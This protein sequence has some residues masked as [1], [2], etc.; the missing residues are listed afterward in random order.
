MQGQHP[1][2]NPPSQHL[3]RRGLLGVPTGGSQK[4]RYWRGAPSAD[5]YPLSCS[6][7]YPPIVP[8]VP[9]RGTRATHPSR[10]TARCTHPALTRALA[11]PFRALF[12][13]PPPQFTSSSSTSSLLHPVSFPLLFI[14]SRPSFHSCSHSLFWSLRLRPTAFCTPSAPLRL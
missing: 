1:E 13:P 7:R 12:L 2:P 6:L 11:R 14:Y 9:H 8:Q 5:R 4:T 10:T 3:F